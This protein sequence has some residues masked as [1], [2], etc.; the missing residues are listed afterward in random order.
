[1]NEINFSKEEQEIEKRL[2]MWLVSQEVEAEYRREMY[3]N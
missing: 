2:E 3:G 1:M